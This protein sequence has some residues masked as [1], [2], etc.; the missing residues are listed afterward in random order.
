[1]IIVPNTLGVSIGVV[2]NF[3][4]KLGEMAMVF[5]S[6]GADGTL[7]CYLDK[8]RD[9]IKDESRIYEAAP[10]PGD[11]RIKDGRKVLAHTHT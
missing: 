2:S 4:G 9:T 3:E 11:I 8:A 6:P 7:K 5:S 1:M 10:K